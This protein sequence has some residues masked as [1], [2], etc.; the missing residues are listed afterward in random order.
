M[1]YIVVIIVIHYCL[2]DG[3]NLKKEQKESLFKNRQFQPHKAQYQY[4]F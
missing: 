1:K 4:L 2:Q 3:F